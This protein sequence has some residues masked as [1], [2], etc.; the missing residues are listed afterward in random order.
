[1]PKSVS[2]IV[3]NYNSA[4]FLTGCITSAIDQVEELIVVDNAS[5]DVSLTQLEARFPG[6]KKLK[7]IRN[8]RNLGFSA[9]CNI[10]LGQSTGNHVMF[11]NPDC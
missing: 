8:S 2:L 1:M 6:E 7:I 5:S 3:V 11:L 4:G 10:G 9:A